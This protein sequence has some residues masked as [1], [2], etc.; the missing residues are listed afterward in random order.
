M[1]MHTPRPINT[2]TSI[3]LSQHTHSERE[4]G[5]TCRTTKP[6]ASVPHE[7]MYC[8]RRRDAYALESSS[9]RTLL[10]MVRHVVCHRSHIMTR[11]I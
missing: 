3:G 1:Q 10:S 11:R 7:E 4:L 6:A 2:S 5:S 8:A 9:R